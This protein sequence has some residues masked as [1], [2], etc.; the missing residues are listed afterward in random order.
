M[1]YIQNT[2]NPL[3]RRKYKMVENTVKIN[4][5]NMHAT[6]L[7]ILGIIVLIIGKAIINISGMPFRGSG[8]G[9]LM[10]IAGVVLLVIAGLRFFIKRH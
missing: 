6:I 9:T 1:F 4:N 8:L 5:F 3:R 10:A 2:A 7:A